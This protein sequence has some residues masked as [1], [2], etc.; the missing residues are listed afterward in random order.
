V[1][2]VWIDV[3]FV[4]VELAA[5]YWFLKHAVGSVTSFTHWKKANK[6]QSPYQLQTNNIYS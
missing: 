4:M 1:N 3:E 2:G 5:R 6:G